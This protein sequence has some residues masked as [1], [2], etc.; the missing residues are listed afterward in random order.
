MRLRLTLLAALAAFALAT[1]AATLPQPEHLVTDTAGVLTETEIDAL[2]AKCAALE[3]A[4]LAQLVIYIAPRLPEGAVMEDL[5]LASVNA[6]GVGDAERNDGLA[7][8]AFMAERKL[9][10]EVGLGLEDVV[11][12]EDA[13]RIIREKIAPAFRKAEYAEGLHAAVD[14]LARLVK[15]SRNR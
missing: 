2:A 1:G 10:I 7:I 6:W 3:K 9:R 8:F 4:K 14:E 11:T 15:A 13:A 12:N 5:T